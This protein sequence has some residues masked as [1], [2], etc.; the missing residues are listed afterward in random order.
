MDR[1]TGSAV[2]DLTESEFQEFIITLGYRYNEKSKAAFNTFEGFHSVIVFREAEN[3]YSLRLECAVKSAEDGQKVLGDIRAFHE[4]H[5]NYVIKTALK[6]RCIEVELKM[7]ID[8][9]LDKEQIRALVHLMTVLFKSGRLA[10]TCR[11]CARQRKTGVYV[12]GKELMPVC[13]ACI[14]RKRRLYERRRDMFDKK[15]Q[16]MAGGI[17]GAVFGALLGGMINVLLY[18]IFPVRGIWSVFVVVLSF[19]GFVVTGRRATR[20]SAVICEIISAL[21]FILSEYAAMI[22]E[23][24]IMIERE[25]GGIAVTEAADIINSGLG[26]MSVLMSGLT[27]VLVGLVVMAAVGGIYLLKRALTR[28]T[29]ISKNL[30]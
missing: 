19:C 30:L 20:K 28:P 11:V 24:A 18:Q 5:K 23:T 14:A 3:R 15:T 13:D 17:V 29:K 4:E 6:R 26:D 16:N 10:P 22:M 2:K 12:I 27:E 8:S 9:E 1:K 7:T 25:G 21:V